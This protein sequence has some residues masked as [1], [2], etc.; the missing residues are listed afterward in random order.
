MCFCV[1]ALVS[2]CL[3]RFQSVLWCGPKT[4]VISCCRRKRYCS[5]RRSSID[6]C[7]GW[8]RW[9]DRIFCFDQDAKTLRWCRSLW[10][11]T[12]TINSH[13]SVHG[14]HRL[15]VYVANRMGPT[16][17][18]SRPMPLMSISR[19]LSHDATTISVFIQHLIIDAVFVLFAYITLTR[20]FLLP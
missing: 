6:I 16:I 10:K 18:V 5:S 13:V 17:S 11:A 7:F 14:I 19:S 4:M 20:I 1:P 12:Q 15:H 2:V 3:S 8:H 9:R